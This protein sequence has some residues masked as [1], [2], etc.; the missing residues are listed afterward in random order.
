MVL[1][2]GLAYA[3][4]ISDTQ[5]IDLSEKARNFFIEATK[6]NIQGQTTGNKFGENVGLSTVEEDI[7]SQGGTLE[8]LQTAE[9][10]SIVSSDTT[11]DISTGSNATSV[12]IFGLDA[13]FTKIEEVVN[14][15]AT[16]T[17][18]TKEY[19]R[20]YRM[21]VESVGNYTHT[22]S[23][24]ITGTAA[25]TGSVQIEISALEGQSETTHYTVPTGHNLIITSMAI[26]M[27]TGKV[28]DV[29]FKVRN[30]ADQTSG[31]T[32]GA[33]REIRTFRGLD[34]PIER[35]SIGNFVLDENTDI[36]ITGTVSTGS[37]ELEANYDFLEYAIGT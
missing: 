30:N 16:A 3:Q 5:V 31:D 8:F 6:G 20:V 19:I 23:G 36:W 28:V 25:I 35:K 21:I 17:N 26:T 14:L 34:T 24:T 4:V 37:A 13:N 27:D 1:V 22:N 11:N 2:I 33:V 18:T 9:L 15:S 32:M 12:R 7:Q 10:I 29:F